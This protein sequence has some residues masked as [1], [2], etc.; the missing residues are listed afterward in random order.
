MSEFAKEK[1]YDGNQKVFQNQE[2]IFG[3]QSYK[4]ARVAETVD[5]IITDSPLLL[6]IAYNNSSLLGEGFNQ[7]VYNIFNSY[8]NINYMLIRKHEYK[9]QARNEDEQKAKELHQRIIDILHKYNVKYGELCT[10]TNNYDMV[11]E[12]I[13][14]YL[15]RI[16]IQREVEQWENTLDN[17]LT[18]F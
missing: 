6:P 16:I 4:M 12:S 11:V 13:I 5:L 18:K 2:Y 7:M 15:P 8:Y 17:V 9:C 3:T 1:W 10:C 14:K